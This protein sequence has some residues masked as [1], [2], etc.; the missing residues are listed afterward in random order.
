[1]SQ[2]ILGNRMVFT[3]TPTKV[4]KNDLMNP[5]SNN[6]STKRLI[7]L[8]LMNQTRYVPRLNNMEKKV[9]DLGYFEGGPYGSGEAPKN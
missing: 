6:L 5:N 8:K 1:M 7:A 2:R 4:N 9:N 3:Y